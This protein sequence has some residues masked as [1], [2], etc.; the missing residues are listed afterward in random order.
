[1]SLKPDKSRTPEPSRGLGR[2]QKIFLSVA[3]VTA[4]L[5]AFALSW[6]FDHPGHTWVIVVVFAP[7]LLLQLALL[8]RGLSRGRRR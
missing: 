3:L 8:A 6:A 2:S 1:M 4:L 7:W 5:A